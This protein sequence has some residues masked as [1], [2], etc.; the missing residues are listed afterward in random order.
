MVPA[1]I[2]G[3]VKRAEASINL[4]WLA[5]QAGVAFVQAPLQGSIHKG[6]TAQGP[7]RHWASGW[8]ASIWAAVT[9]RQGYL[10]RHFHQA[11]RTGSEGHQCSGCTCQQPQHPSVP[12]RRSWV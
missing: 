3:L 6:L 5:Q 12:L 4:R 9:R 10:K 1:L 11:P 7:S 8:S 2:A